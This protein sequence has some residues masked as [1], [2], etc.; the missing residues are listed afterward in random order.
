MLEVLLAANVK[1]HAC[2]AVFMLPVQKV[3]NGFENL[4]DI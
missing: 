3:S 2:S 1:S 4:D